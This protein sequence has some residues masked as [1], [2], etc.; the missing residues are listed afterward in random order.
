MYGPMLA[1]RTQTLEGAEAAGTVRFVYKKCRNFN[2]SSHL[3]NT[4]E[5][6]PSCIATIS[7]DSQEI[8]LILWNPK[9][10]YRI[11]KCLPP[12]P[13]LNNINIVNVS[14]SHFLEYPF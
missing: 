6:S 2:V 14:Q 11:H 5:Y 10:H 12:V 13:I 4:I 7:S 9:V 1:I 8:P 3:A